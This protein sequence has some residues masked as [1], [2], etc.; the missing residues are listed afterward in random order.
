MSQIG[1]DG[2]LPVQAV[3]GEVAPL[4]GCPASMY[5]IEWHGYAG[6]ETHIRRLGILERPQRSAPP[7]EEEAMV[8]G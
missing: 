5:R 6:F 4:P 3:T 7:R 1:K 2:K 8:G